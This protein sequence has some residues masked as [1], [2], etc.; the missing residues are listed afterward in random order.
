MSSP[1]ASPSHNS[2]DEPVPIQVIPPPPPLHTEIIRCHAGR[3]RKAPSSNQPSSSSARP[4]SRGADQ[5]SIITQTEVAYYPG[6]FHCQDYTFRAP[7]PL[8]RPYDSKEGEMVVYVDSLSMGQHFPLSRYYAQ[9]LDTFLISPTQL[10]PNSWSLMGAFGALCHQHGCYPNARIFVCNFKLSKAPYDDECG[11]YAFSS[12]QKNVFLKG[13]TS[14]VDNFRKRWC[15][16][17]GPGIRYNPEWRVPL[18][19]IVIGH[20]E[21]EVELGSMVAKWVAS[22]DDFEV[23]TLIVPEV[24][25]AAEVITPNP[26]YLVP[27]PP[28]EHSSSDDLPSDL[29]SSNSPSSNSSSS[30]SS[31][32]F[33]SIF[34]VLSPRPVASPPHQPAPPIFHPAHDSDSG[35]S[36]AHQFGAY[37]ETFE[38]VDIDVDINY[39]I[40]IE[41]FDDPTLP[42]QEEAG[43]GASVEAEAPGHY[44]VPCLFCSLCA[45][46]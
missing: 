10:T 37:G 23:S 27:S 14:K 11:L 24:L 45:C 29:Q 16:V 32:T 36:T 43:D 2:A 31:G 15:W 38:D 40:D 4:Y 12:V 44:F 1:P 30:S 20:Y 9:I 41:G 3:K 21:P 42:S 19:N 39:D 26:P 33:D 6:R 34:E 22:G 25:A 7:D 28:S 35:A 18:S 17:R 13:L 46:L 8:E 5:R